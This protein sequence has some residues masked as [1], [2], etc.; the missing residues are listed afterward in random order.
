MLVLHVVI[1]T[2]AVSTAGMLNPLEIVLQAGSRG[3]S[4]PKVKRPAAAALLL[5]AVATGDGKTNC[6]DIVARIRCDSENSNMCRARRRT[7]VW[8]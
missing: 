8:N 7:N 2:Q 1:T 5:L 6:M 3:R 4:E